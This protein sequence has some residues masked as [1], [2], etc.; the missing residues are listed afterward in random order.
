[1]PTAP[2]IAGKSPTQIPELPELQVDEKGAE[3]IPNIQFH[4]PDVSNSHS[5]WSPGTQPIESPLSHT[6]LQKSMVNNRTFDNSLSGFLLERIL[7]LDELSSATGT[8]P[9]PAASGSPHET[10][11]R[12]PS[13]LSSISHPGSIEL[14]LSPAAD[15][16]QED[17]AK[18]KQTVAKKKI[19]EQL[20][21]CGHHFRLTGR[22]HSTNCLASTSASVLTHISQPL[23][24]RIEDIN[25]PALDDQFIQTHPHH[26]SEEISNRYLSFLHG[27]KSEDI[28][29][30]QWPI[31]HED[32]IKELRSC[33]EH[34]SINMRK[35][36]DNILAA[37]R[38][39]AQFPHD[40][41][42]S[43]EAIYFQ[44]GH[45]IAPN[46]RTGLIWMEVSLLPFHFPSVTY[47]LQ[48]TISMMGSTRSS[49]PSPHNTEFFPVDAQKKLPAKKYATYPWHKGADM[50][51]VLID[52]CVPP[53][54]GGTGSVF[55]TYAWL[56]TGSGALQ[57][58]PQEVDLLLHDL[59]VIQRV[60]VRLATGSDYADAF[61]VQVRVLSETGFQLLDWTKETAACIGPGQYRLSGL[62]LQN[63]AFLTLDPANSTLFAT[64]H[65]SYVG[66][67]ALLG[68]GLS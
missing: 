31:N 53:A 32:R 5:P 51:R 47:S 11:S 57:L 33:L 12:S 50:Y 3:Y 9:F 44:D 41:L 24:K 48:G 7:A 26:A 22:I 66:L 30:P 16:Q 17:Q 68:P 20:M 46:Q 29:A 45:Q 27:Q 4:I 61:H 63:N 13:P 34:T 1:M 58:F 25:E 67:F 39:H 23:R 18:D 49:T 6:T 43:P 21:E 40:Q 42:C 55:R 62:A 37:I 10:T 14:P 56:D 8:Q 36:R 2:A 52:I 59:T 28:Y 65:R 60:R 64:T 15:G 19:S 54:Q 38:Y 35:N